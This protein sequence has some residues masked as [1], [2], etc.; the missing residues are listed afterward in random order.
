ATASALFVLE[1]LKKM[2]DTAIPRGC[3]HPALNQKFQ[4]GG[5]FQLTGAWLIEN[6]MY[7]CA[8]AFGQARGGRAVHQGSRRQCIRGRAHAWRP[9]S[10][11]SARAPGFRWCLLLLVGRRL[12]VRTKPLASYPLNRFH[13]LREESNRNR[14]T[15]TIARRS[16]SQRHQS[17]SVRG[18]AA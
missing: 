5:G 11:F 9:Q 15:A 16:S 1:W 2:R 4:V 18:A 17:R 8:R 10:A 3:Y 14:G 13:R 7:A 6:C 12:R